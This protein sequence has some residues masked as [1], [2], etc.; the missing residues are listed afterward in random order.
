LSSISQLRNLDLIYKGL[1]DKNEQ[2]TLKSDKANNPGFTIQEMEVEK[3]E[4]I[5]SSILEL[6][7]I[8]HELKNTHMNLRI[9]Q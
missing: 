1:S 2:L 3:N 6:T 5:N 9:S 7:T 8:D 4:N